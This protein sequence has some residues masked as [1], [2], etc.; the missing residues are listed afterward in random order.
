MKKFINTFLKSIDL[1]ISYCYKK[2]LLQLK[3]LSLQR[4]FV[5]TCSSLI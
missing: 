2:Q 1:Y 3:T 5:F 4:L